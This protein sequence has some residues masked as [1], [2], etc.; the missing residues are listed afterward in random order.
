M[1]LTLLLVSA[2][3]RARDS[4][5][6]TD[7]PLLLVSP[8][9]DAHPSTP[10][11]FR[12]PLVNPE[13][14]GVAT[15][16]A[17]LNATA[18]AGSARLRTDTSCQA[19][20]ADPPDSRRTRRHQVGAH[21][22]LGRSAHACTTSVRTNQSGVCVPVPQP[23]GAGQAGGDSAHH[24]TDGACTATS[25][26]E[27]LD[28]AAWSGRWTRAVNDGDGWAWQVGRS[29]LRSTSCNI[30][31]ASRLPRW[32]LVIGDSRGRFLFASLL[33]TINGTDPVDRPP[34]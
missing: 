7:G 27:G 13:I 6:V 17:I 16:I 12:Q 5:T 31:A 18:A 25:L 3:M 14:D 19:P 29:L 21:A 11:T 9:L 34:G 33:A 26:Q 20:R 23:A 28:L 1:K 15:D 30:S 22:H 2:H 8:C 24:K 10:T 32:T 4:I